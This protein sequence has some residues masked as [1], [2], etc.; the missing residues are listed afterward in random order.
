M[1]LPTPSGGSGAPQGTEASFP[2]GIGVNC[3][4]LGGP[5]EPVRAV[6]FQMEKPAAPRYAL[7]D[8]GAVGYRK[9][10]ERLSQTS[11]SSPPLQAPRLLGFSFSA[12]VL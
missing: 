5:S 3:P 9:R 10:Q 4:G 11:V 6:A 2:W 8:R 1:A 7:G 12:P